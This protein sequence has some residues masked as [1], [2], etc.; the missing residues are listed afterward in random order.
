MIKHYAM[1]RYGESGG[2]APVFLT[3]VVDGSE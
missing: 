3:S 2:I 1:K